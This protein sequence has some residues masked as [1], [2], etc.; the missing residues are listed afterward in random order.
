MT[1]STSVPLSSGPQRTITTRWGDTV[2]GGGDG[3]TR[4]NMTPPRSILVAGPDTVRWSMVST[5]SAARICIAATL[6][7][8]HPY[9]H[10]AEVPVEGDDVGAGAGGEPTEVEATHDLGRGG[11]R[12]DERG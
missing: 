8:G 12:R 3:A 6:L 2:T 9:L 1:S 5:N 7:A 4:E 10:H 11:R